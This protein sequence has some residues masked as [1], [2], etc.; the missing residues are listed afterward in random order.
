MRKFFT[1]LL[2]AGL[3]L[4]AAGCGGNTA[5]SGGG[6]ASSSAA[7]SSAAGSSA[8]SEVTVTTDG[9]NTVYDCGGVLIALP[10]KDVDQLVITTEFDTT[11]DTVGTTLFSVS[12]KASQEAMK[13][14]YGEAGGGF[15]FGISRL[16]RAEFEQSIPNNYGG[17]NVFAVDGQRADDRL[18]QPAA[19]TYYVC[20]T[21]TDVQYYRSGGKMDT[22]SQDWK[23]WEALCGLSDTV[24]ADMII[25]NGLTAYTSADF[26]QQKFTYTGGHAFWKH[27]PYF[28]KDGST[29]I[30]DTLVL[31]Q[32]EKHGEGGIWCVERWYDENGNCYVVFPGT[33]VTGGGDVTAEEY[34]AQVQSACDAGSAT[35]AEAALQTPLGAAKSFV[36]TSGW[37]S[38]PDTTDGSFSETD[39]VDQA[40]FDLNGDA[41]QLVLNLE[42]DQSV[43]DSEL[44]N[45]AERFTPDTWGVLGRALYG[46]DW[47]TPLGKALK[48]AAVGDGQARRD[49][50]MIHLYLSYQG[51]TEAISRGLTEVLLSQRTADPEA[52]QSC[53][54]TLSSVEPGRIEQALDA[55]K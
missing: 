15:L 32:P 5:S 10:T 36:A 2:A 19:E 20:T 23:D 16:T 47:W 41:Q 7:G 46:A 45:L 30:Y 52:F 29:A 33:D 4:T 26:M 39:G 22:N 1:A 40:Y 12:E 48:A 49:S 11:D 18:T 54:L 13:K 25:R 9:E 3:L 37:Y 27:Y 42:T 14:D 44:L 21:P 50:A 35:A 53:L 43:K 8:G 31:S 28:G 55:A 6:G 34:Y 51:K 38:A 24:C 17:D